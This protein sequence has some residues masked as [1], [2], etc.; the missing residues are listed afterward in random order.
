MTDHEH[1][2]HE[3]G[4]IEGKRRVYLNMLSEALR[5]LGYDSTEE[6]A[7]VWA[8]ERSETVAMLRTMCE[9]FGDNDWPDDL[10]LPDVIEKHL[11][12]YFEG[13]EE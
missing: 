10:Y 8:Q 13:S 12:C 6:K 5:G 7:A 9:D 2:I 11:C 1:Q 3:R 4:Y